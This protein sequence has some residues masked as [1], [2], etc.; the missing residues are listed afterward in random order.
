MNLNY[1]GYFRS[2]SSLYL[3]CTFLQTLNERRLNLGPN[4]QEKWSHKNGV[5]AWRFDQQA[6]GC[7]AQAKADIW[8]W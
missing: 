8:P 5:T 2:Y 3:L 7:W 1:I 6:E 4:K